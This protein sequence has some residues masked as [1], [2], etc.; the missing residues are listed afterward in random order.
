M[1]LFVGWIIVTV[2]LLGGFI[3]SGGNPAT[4]FVVGEY[5]IIIGIFLG[6]IVAS[7][8]AAVLKMMM[9]SIMTALKGSPYTQKRYIELVQA[10]YQVL[11]LARERGSLD[12]RNTSFNRRRVRFFRSIRVCST[13]ITRF[14]FCRTLFARCSTAR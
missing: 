11:I 10:L 1:L 7:S 13:I 4:L 9:K 5:I 6:Y 8:S 14:I 12:W 3:F 2:A